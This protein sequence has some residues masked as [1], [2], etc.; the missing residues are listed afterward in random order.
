MVPPPQGGIDCER[1]MV[2]RGLFQL[3]AR[4]HRARAFVDNLHYT[5]VCENAMEIDIA[6]VVAHG[7]LQVGWGWGCWVGTEQ[8]GPLM[9]WSTK[10]SEGVNNTL[11]GRPVERASCS[12]I[13]R[14]FGMYGVDDG[15]WRDLGTLAA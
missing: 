6:N 3:R 2:M 1:Y 9:S 8:L 14:G 15:L 13:R 7:Y 12:R 4:H 10:V 11:L 5:N